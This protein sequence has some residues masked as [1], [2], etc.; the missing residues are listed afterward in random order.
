MP[1]AANQLRVLAR[2]RRL[3]RAV[4]ATA[5][6]AVVALAPDAAG[7]TPPAKVVE[8]LHQ[9]YAGVL[10]DSARLPYAARYERLA[11]AIEN[12]YDTTFMARA[13]IGRA[14]NDLS[15]ADQKR[16]AE[17]FKRFMIANYAARLDRD[18]GQRFESLG[19][20][21]GENDTVM[22]LTRV[23]DPGAENVELNYR[24]RKADDAWKIIDVY[25]KGTVSELALR[26]AEY[27]AL[28]K[29]SGF[30][31]LLASLEGKIADLESG[32]KLE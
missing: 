16:W 32:K 20:Q 24:M 5:I 25:A 27:A 18:S 21:K 2:V 7:E 11:P 13:V 23:I 8:A 28:L 6:A 10:K 19:E 9:T 12:A 4:A 26:R 31:A 17:T 22:V 3:R 29:S 1:P 14:W 15:E 30:E